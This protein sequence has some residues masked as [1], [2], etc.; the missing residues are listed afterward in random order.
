MGSI[1]EKV[2]LLLLETGNQF[3]VQSHQSST[4]FDRE[5]MAGLPPPI[6]N[7][8]QFA[9]AVSNE[10]GEGEEDVMFM[11]MQDWSKKLNSHMK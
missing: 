1:E 4:A 6:M 8:N 11:S 3:S 9:Q 2:S 10:P 7:E 5:L